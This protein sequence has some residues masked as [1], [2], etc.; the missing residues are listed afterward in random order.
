MLTQSCHQAMK[1]T[2]G[3]F[4]MDLICKSEKI[5]NDLINAKV[6]IQQFPDNKSLYPKIIVRSW[7]DIPIEHEFRGFVCKKNLNTLSQYFH[8]CY[9]PTLV[10]EKHAIEEKILGYFESIKH[11]INQENYAIDIAVLSD[12]SMRVIEIKPFHHGVQ[13]PFFNWKKGSED[14]S[15]IFNGPF[16]FRIRTEVLTNGKVKYMHPCWIK[17]FLR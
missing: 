10:E 14:R 13:V 17:F 9:F 5:S 1:I 15:I 7:S 2:S 12:G 11:L 16:N 4:A 8:Y 6:L 3:K